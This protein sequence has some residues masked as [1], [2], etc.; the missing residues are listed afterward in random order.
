MFACSP[1]GSLLPRAAWLQ[2]CWRMH[3]GWAQR[4]GGVWYIA[5]TQLA[6]IPASRH[7]P[8]CARPLR[9]RQPQ[10]ALILSKI[11]V[12]TGR[13]LC[14]YLLWLWWRDGA[15]AR[16]GLLCLWIFRARLTWYRDQGIQMISPIKKFQNCALWPWWSCCPLNIFKEI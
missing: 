16:S 7:T 9:T 5:S 10:R 4:L 3:F 13:L 12:L 14:F 8:H 2:R 1:L 15:F 6:C 11:S